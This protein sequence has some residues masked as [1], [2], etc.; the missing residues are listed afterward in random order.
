[1]SFLNLVL[2]NLKLAFLTLGRELTQFGEYG[3]K[4]LYS[5]EPII[6]NL[7]TVAAPDNRIFRF[8]GSLQKRHLPSADETI[9]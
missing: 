2:L 7:G 1:M 4:S 5:R 9:F 8:S 6:R 3:R